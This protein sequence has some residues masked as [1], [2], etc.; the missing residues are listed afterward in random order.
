MNDRIILVEKLTIVVAMK[1]TI[2]IMIITM[3]T[4]T[5]MIMMIIMSYPARKYSYKRISLIA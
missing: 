2:I 3:K 4:R 5:T 1:M